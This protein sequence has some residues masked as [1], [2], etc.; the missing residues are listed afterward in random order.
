MKKAL[1]LCCLFASLGCATIGAA[2]GT[3][4]ATSI[5]QINNQPVLSAAAQHTLT[6]EDYNTRGLYHARQK[7]YGLAEKD[8]QQAISLAQDARWRNIYSNN[9]ALTYAY[10]GR[11][12]LALTMIND[13][14]VQDPGLA[15]ALDTKGDILIGLKRYE[16]AESCLTNAILLSPGVGTPYYNRGRAYEGMKQMDKAVQDYRKAL[17]LPGD[18]QKEARQRLHE[19]KLL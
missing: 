14:L 2:D 15:N 17:V 4:A 9:L 13:V 19:L 1:A 12:A 3:V 6:A 5:T 16:E 8:F 10:M 7:A 11:Y 18:Y